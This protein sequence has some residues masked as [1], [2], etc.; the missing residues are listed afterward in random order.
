VDG[1]AMVHRLT[2]A[3]RK[4]LGEVVRCGGLVASAK[5]LSISLPTAR[6]HLQHIFEKTG[7]RNQVELVA[8]VLCSPLRPR[9]DLGR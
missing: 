5:K 2:A 3:E 1:F 4:V 7:A 9:A 8:Q 6:T